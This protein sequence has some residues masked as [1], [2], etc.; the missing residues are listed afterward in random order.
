MALPADKQRK[1]VS[2][3]GKIKGFDLDH[4][5]ADEALD[6]RQFHYGSLCSQYGDLDNA[7][8]ARIEE[9]A[10]CCHLRDFQAALHIFDALPPELSQH[11]VVVY[12]RSQVYWLDWSLYECEKVLEEG[13]AW[14]KKNTPDSGRPGVYTL[15]RI[16]LGRTKVY[17]NGN[18]REARDAMRETKAWLSET[19]I[20]EYTDVQVSRVQFPS[21]KGDLGLTSL[22][23]VPL[24]LQLLFAP[25]LL[26]PLGEQFRCRVFQSDP[27]R[28][29][30]ERNGKAEPP[31]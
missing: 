22:I 3:E 24:R 5:E 13:I 16:V 29:R 10:M 21:R 6:A 8:I 25:P 30:E 20:E 9:A 19:P 12:E 15:L 27:R 1:H 28:Y 26:E 11:P 17:T 14:S 23:K 31:P 18:F 4:A 2:L 7:T